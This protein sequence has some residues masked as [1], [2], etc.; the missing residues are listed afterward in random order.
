MC[1]RMSRDG[2][3]LPGSKEHSNLIF[4][5]S[6][7]YEVF[8]YGELEYE[9]I[10]AGGCIKGDHVTWFH[11]RGQKNIETWFLLGSVFMRFFR[12]LELEYE[13]IEANRRVW[14]CHVTASHSRGQKN[15]GIWIW[16]ERVSD[17]FFDTGNSD[18]SESELVAVSEGVTWRGPTFGVKRTSESEFYRRRFLWGFS[19][20]GTR[21]WVKRSWSMCGR[22]SCDKVPLPGSK[23][24]QNLIFTRERY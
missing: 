15:N 22:V 3:P 19:A 8:R 5:G 18:M 21:I 1:Q 10:E 6:R 16:P 9:W 20:W 13:W 17:R 23:E 12:Y 11:F 4:A 24:H 14:M 2:V 7:F